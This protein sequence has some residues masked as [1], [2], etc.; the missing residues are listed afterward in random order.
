M[1]FALAVVARLAHRPPSANLTLKGITNRPN[2]ASQNA[3]KPQSTHGF[4]A[5]SNTCSDQITPINQLLPYTSRAI[6]WG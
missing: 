5:K 1:K 6:H 3:G 2:Q 4:L